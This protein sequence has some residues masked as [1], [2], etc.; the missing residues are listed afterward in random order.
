[1]VAEVEERLSDYLPSYVKPR[2]S[3]LEELLGF[4][5]DFSRERRLVVV[6]DEF[7]NFTVAK[8]SFFSSL[9]ELCDEKKDGSNLMLIAVGSYVGMIKRIFMDR[10]EPLFGRADEWMKLKPFD[11]WG[12]Y[13]LCVLWLM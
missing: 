8:S 10:K 11:F 12:A 4:L 2:F 6:F 1:M 7:Q 13:G 3:S 5:L 9:Q